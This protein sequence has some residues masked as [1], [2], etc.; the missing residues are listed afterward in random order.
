MVGLFRFGEWDPCYRRFD[1][2][3]YSTAWDACAY[4]SLIMWSSRCRPV[5]FNDISPAFSDVCLRSIMLHLR[6]VMFVYVQLYFT[7]VQ[8][9]LS[10]FNY[11]APTFYNRNIS[12]TINNLLRRAASTG[13]AA[14]LV[15]AST[16]RAGELLYSGCRFCS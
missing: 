16:D 2:S 7:C 1:S 14:L 15:A 5:S 13:R 6:S 3:S 10:T 11:T 8:W 12:S 9:C 4:S